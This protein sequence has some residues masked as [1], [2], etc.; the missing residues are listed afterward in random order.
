MLKSSVLSE[1]RLYSIIVIG[2]VCGSI[3][4][5]ISIVVIGSSVMK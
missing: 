4:M 1:F 2:C 5:L 3:V